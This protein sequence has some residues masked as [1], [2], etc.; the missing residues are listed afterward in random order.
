MDLKLI[1]E[2]CHQLFFSYSVIMLQASNHIAHN[3]GDI[4]SIFVFQFPAQE[5]LYSF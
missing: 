4:N 5:I 1:L 3:L 2:E